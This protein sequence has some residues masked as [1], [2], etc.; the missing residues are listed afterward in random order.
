VVVAELAWLMP[1]TTSA[2]LAFSPFCVGAMMLS[3][4]M[5]RPTRP[6]CPVPKERTGKQ[7][8]GSKR[9]QM[10][11]AWNQFITDSHTPIRSR[12]LA[13]PRP[14][15]AMQQLVQLSSPPSFHTAGVED[16]TQARWGTSC[17][18]HTKASLK[19]PRQEGDQA[20]QAPKDRIRG[21]AWPGQNAGLQT[22]MSHQRND[23][24]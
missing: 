7:R 23:A 14:T 5:Q 19:R 17:V 4:G 18:S 22:G 16:T 21:D 24:K 12:P 15:R 10:A 6:R 11:S 20:S 1:L 13:R 9:E 8:V 2:P 3:L